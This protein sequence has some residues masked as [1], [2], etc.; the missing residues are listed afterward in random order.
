V[1]AGDL[2]LTKKI[3]AILTKCKALFKCIFY[4][5]DAEILEFKGGAAALNFNRNRTP[6]RSSAE[7]VFSE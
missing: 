1:F 4:V 3:L 6:E 2:P 7:C 5:F